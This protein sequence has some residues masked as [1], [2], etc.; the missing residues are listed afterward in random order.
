MIRSRRLGW[1]DHITR[2]EEGGNVFKLLARTPAERD[3]LESQGVD[4]RTLFEWILNKSVSIRGIGLI[5]LRIG[6]I[7]EPL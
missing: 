2:M 3:L 6:I 1:A 7:G 5:R 4:G